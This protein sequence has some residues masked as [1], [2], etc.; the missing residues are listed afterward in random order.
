V[1]SRVLLLNLQIKVA[2]EI[3]GRYSVRIER[4]RDDPRAVLI[5]YGYGFALLFNARYRDAAAV[6]QQMSNMAQRLGDR[7][8]MACA[9]TIESVVSF[10]LAPKSMEDFTK[11]K[12]ETI[13]VVSN[14]QDA[15]IDTV[16]RSFIAIEEAGRGR[17]NDAR[18]TAR[19]LIQVGQQLNDPRSIGL[20]L[21]IL[22][23]IALFS[24]SA[25]EALEYCEQSLA[26]SITQQD[27]FGARNTKGSA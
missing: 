3:L 24:D 27:R 13:N 22:A 7:M 4:L 12:R 5:G 11:F 10:V 6:Q 15:F 16:A 8:S 25:A 20:G 14:T 21:N 18:D 1:Y 2:I 26:V 17:M 23:Q 19:G 9:L